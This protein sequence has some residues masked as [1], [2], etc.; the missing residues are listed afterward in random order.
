MSCYLGE[1]SYVA[2]CHT[3]N[4]CK[5]L[6]HT[7]MVMDLT[8]WGWEEVDNGPQKRGWNKLSYTSGSISSVIVNERQ[9]SKK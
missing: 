2:T 4:I 3:L 5:T 7:H 8:T 6:H 1:H 9:S